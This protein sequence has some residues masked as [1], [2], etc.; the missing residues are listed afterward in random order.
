MPKLSIIVTNYKNP[1]LLW[2]CLDSIRKNLSMTDYET[3]VADSATEEDTALMMKDEFPE[4]T[5]IPSKE[6]VGFGGAV[7]NG[8]GKSS[9]EYVLVLNGDIIIKKDSIET[10]LGYIEKN[11]DVGIVGPK[12]LNFNETFQLSCFRFYTPLT[13]LYRRTFL[14]RFGFAKNHLDR[15]L[16][17]GFDHKTIKEVDWLMGSA[18]MTRRS[19]IEE[20]GL[21][22]PQFNMYFE[23]TDW[24]RRFWEK[25]YK[26]VFNPDSEMYHY[27]GRGSAGKN[28]L[29]LLVSN[30]LTWIHIIS[31]VKY[32]RKY[33]GKPLPEHN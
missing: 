25:G 28:I 15:F 21:L 10:L 5:F 18:L 20:I 7:R 14:G 4:M 29:K 23:D 2:V 12:L 27:H 22:D 13:I 33:W 31:S 17:K 11:P 30:R 8:Y 19:M 1:D 16:M 6:N 26:V 9:G 32:F 3:I 24:C